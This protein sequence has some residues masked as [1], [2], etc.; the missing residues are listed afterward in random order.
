VKTAVK[1]VLISLV[2]LL[3]FGCSHNYYN[4]P[5]DSFEKK[6]RV[7]GIAPIFVD[8]DS[9]IRHPDK[10]AL[11]ALLTEVNRQNEPELVALLKDQGGFFSVGLLDETPDKLFGEL[12]FRRER[13]DDAG[14]MY[15]KYFFKTDTLRE[16]LKKHHLDAVMCVVVSGLVRRDKVYSSTLLSSLE[17]D[18][19][20]LIVTAEIIDADG[21]ILWE[22][23]NFRQRLLSFPTLYPLQYPDF[24]EA[25]ANESEQVAVKFKTIPG[26]TRAFN[27]MAE[28]S[29]RTGGK[30][31]RLY[32]TIF[33]D[34][35]SY[36]GPE[37]SLFGSKN[38]D[39]PRPESGQPKQ[40]NGQ[41][42]PESVKPTQENVRPQQD[43]VQPK[44][45]SIQPKPEGIL[46]EPEG[47]QTKPEGGQPEQE[48][49]QPAAGK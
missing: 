25:K 8:A 12:F 14:I 41:P 32:R 36:L 11:V 23:P 30:V 16:L 35:I 47:S 5:R 9:D 18:Y 3:G 13:R 4:V 46:P 28:S 1:L 10:E 40:E 26:I 45:E 6:V 2:A 49:V 20:F 48:N 21:T 33:S 44:P 27:N 39:Q 7:I 37:R 31:S 42:N 34:M 38:N 22:Y 15:N 29:L 43:S 19:N 24:D 17:S